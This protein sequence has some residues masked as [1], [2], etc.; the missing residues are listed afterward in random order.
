M[1]SATTQNDFLQTERWLSV[2]EIASHLGVSRESIYRWA[3]AGKMPAHKVGRK[4]K[5]WVDEI[6]EWVKTGRAAESTKNKEVSR[7]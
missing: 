3:E 5:F 2:E 6:N 7:G 4:W 1:D